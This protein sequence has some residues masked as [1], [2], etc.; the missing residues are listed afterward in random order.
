MDELIKHFG[1]QQKLANALNNRFGTKVST[2]HVYY[3]LKKGIPI[4]R[5]KQV[6]LLTGGEFTR[7]YLRPDLYN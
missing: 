4:K 5:A 1:T 3:W 2:G 6:E 7:F